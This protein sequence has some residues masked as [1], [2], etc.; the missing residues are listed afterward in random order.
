M[1]LQP[2]DN[3][4]VIAVWG[5]GFYLLDDLGPLEAMADSADRGDPRL[6]PIRPSVAYVESSD[7][8]G[9]RPAYG[10]A[11][12]NPAYG[13]W[14]HY[15]LPSGGA[16]VALAIIDGRGWVVR[17][18]E[19][20]NGSGLHRVVWNLRDESHPMSAPGRAEG[21]DAGVAVP[22]GRYAARLTVGGR[23]FE[24]PIEV[25]PDQRGE[26]SPAALAAA[27]ADRKAVGEAEYR[28][29]QVRQRLAGARAAVDSIDGAVR[30]GGG[31]NPSAAAIDSVRAGFRAID[32]AL[33]PTGRLPLL[34]G[35]LGTSTSPL[36]RSQ[37]AA[38]VAAERALERIGAAVDVIVDR[39]VPALRE[40][41]PP[42]SP[43]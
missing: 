3:D 29:R 40:S 21:G 27:Y 35:V 19:A 26:R 34:A 7:F 28:T 22:P 43:P 8:S 16:P 10:T 2:R 39:R 42:G 23:R 41:A 33:G 31:A 11:L 6:F 17:R 38:L 14:V 36:S 25:R 37:R 9:F 13:A 5:R 1:T 24:T 20:P 12:P 18:F 30:R 4:L 32:V 15:R